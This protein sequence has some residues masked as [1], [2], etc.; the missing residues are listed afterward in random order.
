MSRLLF[1]TE[2]LAIPIAIG[3]TIALV[4]LAALASKYALTYRLLGRIPIINWFA[5]ERITPESIKGTRGA[6]VEFYDGCYFIAAFI[7]EGKVRT[8]TGD[9]LLCKLYCPSAPI[10]WSG[11]PIIFAERKRVIPLKISFAEVYQI[12]TSFGRS[13]REVMEEF[14]L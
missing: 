10:P 9:L 2:E 1:N 8:S 14:G 13:T 3:I 7:G 6:L 12:T 4:L 11:L 5:G